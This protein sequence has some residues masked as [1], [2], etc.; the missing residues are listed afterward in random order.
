MRFLD[1]FGQGKCSH[2]HG[3]GVSDKVDGLYP[4][5]IMAM[6]SYGESWVLFAGSVQFVFLLTTVMYK[7]LLRPVPT[8]LRPVAA[9]KRH[10]VGGTCMTLC[11]QPRL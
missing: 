5:F 10:L 9:G 7:S 4:D 3:C 6:L 2:V 1:P 11:T 8:W